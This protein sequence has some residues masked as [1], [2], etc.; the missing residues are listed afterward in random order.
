MTTKFILGVDLHNKAYIGTNQS[1]LNTGWPHFMDPY[2]REST[3]AMV[4]TK[5]T[6]NLSVLIALKVASSKWAAFTNYTF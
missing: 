5:A 1:G 4:T 3:D 6:Y 2:K